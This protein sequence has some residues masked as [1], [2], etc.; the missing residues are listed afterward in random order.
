MAHSTVV[1]GS[2]ARLRRLCNASIEESKGKP[3]KASIYAVNGTAL[4]TVI[5]RAL[6]GD[7]SDDEVLKEFTGASYV[8]LLNDGNEI[9]EFGH[10]KM[11]ADALVNKGLPALAF[12]DETV[13]QSAEFWLEQK[14]N[15]EPRKKSPFGKDFGIVGAFGTGDVFFDDSEDSGRAGLIDWKMGDGWMVDP[16]NEED[17]EQFLFYLA[18]AIHMGLLPVLDKYEAWVFQ[19][20]ARLSP[21]E[22]GKKAVFT[23][24]EIQVYAEDLADSIHSERRYVTGKH[25]KKCEGKVTCT[26]F[27]NMLT[28]VIE[29]DIDGVSNVEL[30]ALVEQVDAIKEFCKEVVEA[31]T[32]NAL[33]GIDIP[34]YEIDEGIGKGDRRYKDE[35]AAGGALGRLGLSAKEKNVTKLLSAP[36]ALTLLEKKGVQKKQIEAFERRHVERPDSK[37]RLVKIKDGKPSSNGMKRLAAALEAQ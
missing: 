10:N 25:C 19:P 6:D 16:T 7:L 12:F 20:A 30:A 11:E 26:A 1:G 14:V 15:L 9:E 4:H 36:Q 35:K 22:Y 37:P 33:N 8:D 5:E 29:T 34:G 13:P 2:T 24:K 3:N 31:A 28:N 18:C 17:R 23:F 21:D 27:R 32:R